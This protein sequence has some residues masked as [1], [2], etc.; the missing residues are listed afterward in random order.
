MTVER[1]IVHLF[2]A[3]AE[4][5]PVTGLI[6]NAGTKGAVD[7]LGLGLAKEVADEGRLSPVQKV[8]SPF[9]PMSV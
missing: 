6:A 5:G 3:A 7:T 1:D 8:G 2:E 4:L 9:L